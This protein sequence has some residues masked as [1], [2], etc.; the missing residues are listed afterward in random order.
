MEARSGHCSPKTSTLAYP[1]HSTTP[2]VLSA[3]LHQGLLPI[4]YTAQVISNIRYSQ[5]FICCSALN[6][7]VYSLCHNM[8]CALLWYSNWEI[9]TDNLL[10]T[11]INIFNI[12]NKRDIYAVLAR[13]SKIF[14]LLLKQCDGLQSCLSFRL[15]VKQCDGLQSSLSLHL[16]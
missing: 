10:D 4:S 6:P 5:R 11:F 9:L 16:F 15:L 2:S 14:G 7:H 1:S 8:L 13:N 12:I 3:L